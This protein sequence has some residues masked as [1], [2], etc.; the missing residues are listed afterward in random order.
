MI[1][2]TTGLKKVI[3]NYWILVVLVIIKL[4]MQYLFVNPVYELHRDEF[5]HLDQ[6]LHP[7][8]GYISVPPFTSWI[9]SLI[10]LLGGGIF[11]IRF[12]PAL[13]GALTVVFGWLIA[14]SLGGKLIS[15]ILTSV[16][17]IFSVYIRLNLLF[18][19]NAFDILAWTIMFWLL[20]RY[21][22]DYRIKWLIAL[23]VITALGLYNKYTVLFL[24]AGL[25][26]GLLITRQRV[27]LSEKRILACCCT[28][29]GFIPA[30]HYLA[31]SQWVSSYP[32]HEGFK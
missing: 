30:Q 16:F 15:K 32:P 24:L 8:W 5:L 21:L 1:S 12:F 3:S 23:A 19:P 9:A 10:Y 17:I 6:A 26:A 18:Q 31:G 13:F 22:Q 7:A 25:F 28:N 20:I 4:V 29:S 14:E 11:W 27:L 2:G